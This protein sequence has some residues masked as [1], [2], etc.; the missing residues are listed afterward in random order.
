MRIANNIAELVG[1]TPLVRLNRIAKNA[2]AEIDA[3]LEFY[4]P[5]A[6]VKD[7]IAAA[8]IEA[9][10]KNGIIHNHSVLVEPTSGN[11]GVG[12]A[13]IA[14][15]KGYKLIITM[16]ESMSK[17]R[18]LLIKALGAE[19]VLTPGADGMAGAI[20]KAKELVENH[21]D[22]H[23]MLQ[24]FENSANPEI[25]RKTTAEEIWRDTDGY[26]CGRS[27]YRGD[28]NWGSRD[29]K[30]K[31]PLFNSDC[32]GTCG[33]SRTFGRS[34]RIALNSRYRRWFYP[35]SAEYQNL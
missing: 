35:Q 3:K 6:S 8:M 31:K 20:A 17:E 19:L 1:N 15:A 16:P 18:K 22:T 30:T 5:S 28:I 7:R 33:F 23:V 21:P 2:V 34:K 13:T 10:E 12:L 11:T 9:A 25:H 4:N 26:F 14:A 27:G 24:Q 29:F 32:G